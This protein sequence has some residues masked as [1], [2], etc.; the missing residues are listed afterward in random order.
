MLKSRKPAQGNRYCA[1]IT[2]IDSKGIFG[3]VNV[4]S[5]WKFDFNR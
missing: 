5:V 2:Q 1:T 4:L 3:N